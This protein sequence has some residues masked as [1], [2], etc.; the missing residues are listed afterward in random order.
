[1]TGFERGADGVFHCCAFDE[2][3]W[4]QHGFGT[5]F[6]SPVAH[7]TLR[8]IHSSIV[9][10]ASGLQDR[11]AEGDALITDEIGRAIGVRTADCVPLLLLDRKKRAVAAIHAGW[12]GTAGQIV[13]AAT[14]K[15]HHDLKS[16]PSDILAAIGPCIRGCC[17][18][19]SADVA[20][21][22]PEGYRREST[23]PGKWQLD[24]AAANRDQLAAGGVPPDQI[25]D[26][27][28]CTACEMNAFFSYRREPEN[29]G[30]LI[31]SIARLA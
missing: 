8:Q 23:K 29:P 4:Q 18:E 20:H 26:L 10:N 13:R 11:A 17:Y 19:V 30:R 28:A 1:V 24:L 5:R 31:S 9:L 14:Q 2:F 12:R 16:T 27:G 21:Q 15:L 25:F 22:F 3:S 6:A 7:V